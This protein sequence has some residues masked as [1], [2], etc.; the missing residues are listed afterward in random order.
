VVI[1]VA[2]NVLDVGTGVS[3]VSI[4]GQ[5]AARGA[6]VELAGVLPASPEG[7]RRLIAIARQGIRHAALLRSPA[8]GMEPADL[9]LALRYLPNAGV[10]VLVDDG[11]GLV[12]TA[13]AAAAWAGAG[14][15]V[16]VPHGAAAP[17]DARGGM[18]LEAPAAD[19][20]GTFAGFVADLAARLDAGE[21]PAQVWR[22]TLTAL[23]VDPIGEAP[24]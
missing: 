4:A 17:P 13:A 12:P 6:I 3:A 2:G 10:I 14:L 18:V 19:P 22:A 11:G 16:V 15:V 1:V 7:D 24:A 5:A 8:A 20:E 21:E 23:A 9:E